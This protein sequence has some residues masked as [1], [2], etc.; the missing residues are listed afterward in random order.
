MKTKI[1]PKAFLLI[2]VFP[3]VAFAF[4]TM[5]YLVGVSFLNYFN[6]LPLNIELM[7]SYHVLTICLPLG[8]FIGSIYWLNSNITIYKDEV[9]IR[10]KITDLKRKKIKMG[11]IVEITAHEIEAD[12]ATNKFHIILKDA[13]HKIIE[14]WYDEAA[15]LKLAKEIKSNN[16]KLKV[17][18]KL[19]SLL[20]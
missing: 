20:T 18:K 15:L 19:D 10:S 11:D 14:F 9:M 5:L 6:V 4:V 13:D 12:D 16:P 8:F 17:D 1:Y 7:V 3:L 2:I